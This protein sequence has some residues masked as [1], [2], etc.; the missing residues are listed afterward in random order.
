MKLVNF[1]TNTQ[2][3][4][5]ILRILKS[6]VHNR[7]KGSLVVSIFFFFPKRNYFLIIK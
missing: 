1:N 3:F 7:T 6:F 2:N 5:R 4:I